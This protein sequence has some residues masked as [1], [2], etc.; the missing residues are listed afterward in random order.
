MYAPVSSDPG[1]SAALF[2]VSSVLNPS[3][4]VGPTQAQLEQFKMAAI[5]IDL[6][7]YDPDEDDTVFEDK[8]RV[9]K[10]TNSDEDSGSWGSEDGEDDG[11]GAEDDGAG[12]DD[13]GDDGAG[14]G[15]AGIDGVE[16]NGAG[17]NA[18]KSDKAVFKAQQTVENIDGDINT[19]NVAPK[20]TTD[21]VE[22][23]IGV[24]VDAQGKKEVKEEKWP[25]LMILGCGK[26]EVQDLKYY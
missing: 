3:A 19:D 7:V 5:I 10:T 14:D 4:L 2:S 22:T 23:D 11:N 26:L 17:S 8:P 15:G 25:Q 21:R 6:H 20:P 18:S 24:D 16:S 12:S 9:R 13:V 1:P